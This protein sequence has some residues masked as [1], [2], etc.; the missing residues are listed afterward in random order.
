VHCIHG[1]SG[2][3]GAALAPTCRRP[4]R[5]ETEAGR[6]IGRRARQQRTEGVPRPLAACAGAG[7][8]FRPDG[9][10]AGGERKSVIS[11]TEQP[12]QA[13]ASGRAIIWIIAMPDYARCNPPDLKRAVINPADL[14]RQDLSEQRHVGDGVLLGLPLQVLCQAPAV[15]DWA[16]SDAWRWR[17]GA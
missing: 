1:L 6:R 2:G 4:Q 15:N 12:L 17:R 9:T 5:A 14:R 10:S 8:R 3:A 16:V 7:G 11:V 13:A